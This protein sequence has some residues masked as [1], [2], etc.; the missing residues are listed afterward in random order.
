MT[1]FVRLAPA[2]QD[3]RVDAP[4]RS[5]FTE[6]LLEKAAEK[7]A[8]QFVGQ[9][10]ILTLTE[11]QLRDHLNQQIEAGKIQSFT[12]KES[13]EQCFMAEVFISPDNYTFEYRMELRKELRQVIDGS[14]YE[15]GI[16]GYLGAEYG[17]P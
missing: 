8:Q 15:I 13:P 17:E 16:E 11:V 6:L 1:Q 14:E 5:T 3:R 2:N 9:G 7:I 4:P 12:L 10:E